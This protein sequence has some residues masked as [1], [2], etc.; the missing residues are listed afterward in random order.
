M[1]MAKPVIVSRTRGIEDYVVDGETGVY[2]EPGNAEDLRD[3]ICKVSD[4]A[5]LRKRLGTNARQTVE[6]KI[7][8][9]IYADRVA[10][11]ILNVAKGASPGCRE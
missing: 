8:L 3:R 2:V 11:I 6:E 1:S 9:D 10:E 7:N 4:S 5:V